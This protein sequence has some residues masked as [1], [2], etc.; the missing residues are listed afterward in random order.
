M[1]ERKDLI[2]CWYLPRI[3]NTEYKNVCNIENAKKKISSRVICSGLS[4]GVIW[5]ESSRDRWINPC[6]R[7]SAVGGRL[8]WRSLKRK[9][10]DKCKVSQFCNDIYLTVMVINAQDK[11]SSQGVPGRGQDLIQRSNTNYLWRLSGMSWMKG[12]DIQ[13]KIVTCTIEKLKYRS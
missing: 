8:S 1:L 7:K 4:S 11:L 5:G 10:R 3:H 6:H 12:Q 9:W 13:H 2:D